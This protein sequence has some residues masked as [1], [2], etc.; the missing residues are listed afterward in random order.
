M[1]IYLGI[2][3]GGSKTSFVVGDEDSL[4]G[5]AA[6]GGSNVL[7][8]GEAQA[9]ESLASGIRR[10]CQ[11]AKITPGQI[12]RTCI[13]VAGA[14]R[15]E[16]SDTVQRILSRLL[17]SE[18]KVVGDMVIAHHAAF[19]PDA[20]VI[21]IAGTGS[22]AYGRNFAGVIARAGGWGFAIS[23]EG[24]GQWIGRTAVSSAMRA[25]DEGGASKLLQDIL[26]SLALSSREDLVIFAN[27]AP[28]PN[29]SNLFPAV[30]AAAESGDSLAIEIMERAGREL[31]NLSRIVADR[32]FLRD[33]TIPLAMAGGVF[34]NSATVRQVFSTEIQSTSKV[35]VNETV[36]DPVIGALE[37]ARL[38]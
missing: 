13:G 28:S 35:V 15:S 5:R 7:K 30:L 4:L 3:G 18:I 2:D 33:A 22:I 34:Q 16:I 23:D 20:G 8:V 37:L 29:F 21:V 24:S 14:G 11:L 6:S 10:L 26:H 17:P 25:Y 19:G 9:Q 36:V 32:I 31:A 1:G 12:T 27:A 38:D